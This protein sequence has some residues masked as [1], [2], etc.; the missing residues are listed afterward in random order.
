MKKVLSICL[1][2]VILL[3]LAALM[4]CHEEEAAPLQTKTGL[5]FTVNGFADTVYSISEGSMTDVELSMIISLQGVLA[6]TEATIYIEGSEGATAQRLQDLS[7]KHGFSIET[8]TDPWALVDVFADVCSRKYVLYNDHS[9]PDVMVT[10][11]TINYAT[12]ISGAEGWLMISK[13]L[14]AKAKEHGLTLGTDA[15]AE[16]VNTRY[17]FEAYKEK[18]NNAYLVHQD[19]AN[20][21]LRDYAIAGKALCFYSDMYDGDSSVKA[22][23]LN[24]AKENAPILGW[25]ANELNFVSANSLRSMVTV[26]ADHAVNLSLY[27]ASGDEVLKQTNHKEEKVQAQTGKH[28][29]AIVMS[30]GDNVQW[31]TRGFAQSS[32]YYGSVY[33]G[34]FPMTWTTSPALYDLAPDILGGMYETASQNDLFIAGPSGV[35]YIN[36]TEYN[37]DSLDDYA[38]YTAGYM[39]ATDLQYVNF[40]DNYVDEKMLDHFSAFTQIKGGIWSLGD[41]YIE[42]AGSVYWSNGKPFVAVRE[43]LWRISGDDDSN[44]YYGFVERVAQRINEYSTDPTK[45]EGYTVVLAH[46]WSVGS[47]EYI[48][49]FVEALDEDVV[50]VTVDQLL[51]MVSENVEPVNTSPK[52]ISKEDLDD[53]LVPI[54]SEQYDWDMV[55]DTAV[56][57]VRDFVFDSEKMI[58]TWNSGNGGLQYD[59]VSWSGSDTGGKPALQ[60]D[61]S[62]LD[63]VV[64]PLPNSWIYNMFQISDDPQK[65]NFLYC[66]IAG[67]ERADVNFRVRALYEENG[68]VKTVVLPSPDYAD[69]T[70]DDYG[71]YKRTSSSPDHFQYDLSALKGRKVLISIEQDDTGDGTGEIVFVHQIVISGQEIVKASAFSNWSTQDVRD[72]WMVSG[73]VET[74][75]EGVCLEAADGESSISCTFT[76][77]EETRW[78]KFYVRMFVRQYNPDTNPKLQC[79]VNGSVL[80]AYNAPG[81]FVVVSSDKYRCI[82]Y[83][84][85]D[86]ISQ[87]ITITFTSLEGQHA[88]IA[89]IML[90][91]DCSLAEVNN[92]YSDGQVKE[93]E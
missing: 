58:H 79:S 14:E 88:A 21:N 29:V 85:S 77:T 57:D 42:G 63:D 59:S 23:I 73:T 30:D 9:N 86:Y 34:Q 56:T 28:Y 64:D 69:S 31:M 19:P 40:L 36:A 18:L 39:E 74:H 3:S 6:Q 37:T 38:A 4:G 54:S 50:L 71:W 41:K 46:A 15:T 5:F 61:G 68:E 16:G 24:W 62:D 70:V 48:H 78:V 13:D 11:Q 83:D 53:R 89:R 47:M 12:T 84:L 20:R 93:M 72:D 82:A 25:T 76:V 8:V 45:I 67:G 90:T 51:Q 7:Q 81:D 2:L 1:V 49:R 35:G 75:S 91:E 55:K 10:D 80:K 52:D 17:I 44:Q 60:L 65:D 43:T 26:A 87:E 92:L 22:D 27:S 33:R 66:Y 32:K